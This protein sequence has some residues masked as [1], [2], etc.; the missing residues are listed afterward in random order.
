MP[1]TKQTPCCARFSARL[2][3]EKANL[4]RLAQ[5]AAKRADRGLSIVDLQLKIEENKAAI[6]QVE[7]AIV[8]HEAR[9]AGGEI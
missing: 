7:D 2:V 9:H 4:R 1:Q 8:D 3:M 6:K 5:R